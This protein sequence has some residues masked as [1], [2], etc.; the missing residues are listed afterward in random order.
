M[1]ILVE[2]RDSGDWLLAEGASSFS[3]EVKTVASGQSLVSGQ[4]C[5][6]TSAGKKAA[7]TAQGNESHKYTFTGTPTAGTFTLTLYHKDGY[8]V[9][10]APIAFDATNAVLDAAIEAVLGTSSVA[11]TAT[12]QGTAITDLTIVHSGTGYASKT[13]PL[14]QCDITNLTG[15]T[16]VAVARSVPAGV[17]ADEVQTVAIGGT[18][19]GG[20][21]RLGIPQLD[22]S[23]AWTDTIAHNATFSTVVS[24]A[25]TAIDNLLGT[26]NL[27]VVAGSAYTAI[28]LT[29]SGTGYTT[30]SWP[31]VELDVG[32]LTGATTSTIS[33]TTTG[34]AAGNEPDN[35]ADSISLFDVDASA[36]DVDATFI[37][38]DAVVNG[39]QL[40][41]GGGEP[42]AC[43]TALKTVGI[44]VRDEPA[45]QQYTTV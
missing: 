13:F 8:W 15:V 28:T 20:S 3:R 9:Q 42:D 16:A 43:K 4:V 12:G 30:L 31:L 44:I 19:S 26:A 25:Q 33:R 22:G 27:I 21:F 17:G 29:F 2:K 1:S 32:A 35:T 45:I 40:E 24:N 11:A 41:Y 38:R 5:R 18:V 14:G 34:G 23:I 36:A 10:T 39:S 6:T 7:L 37:V